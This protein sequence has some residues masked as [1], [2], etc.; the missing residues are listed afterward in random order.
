MKDRLTIL[1][2]RG[3]LRYFILKALSKKKMH[4]YAIIE[5]CYAATNKEWKPSFGSL[6]PM[7]KKLEKNGLIKSSVEKHGKRV[8]KVYSITKKGKER[9]KLL[10][11]NRQILESLLKES[12]KTR[13]K[14]LNAFEKIDA[15]KELTA[16]RNAFL[17][18]TKKIS[19][20]E[21]SKDERKKLKRTILKFAKEIENAIE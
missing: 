9:L 11:K 5:S 15:N 6:Y 8:L 14:I 4:G 18:I 16:L 19:E 17:K 21:P 1:L 20:K 7:L 3:H 12:E 2:F 10:E 13:E